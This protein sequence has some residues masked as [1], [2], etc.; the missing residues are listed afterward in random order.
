M[1]KAVE[2]MESFCYS[3]FVDDDPIA[4]SYNII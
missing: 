3:V 2:G 4:L 1:V